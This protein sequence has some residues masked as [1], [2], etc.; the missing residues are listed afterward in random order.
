[1]RNPH[2]NVDSARNNNADVL[3]S[4]SGVGTALSS[5]LHA[6]TCVVLVWVNGIISYHDSAIPRSGLRL[7]SPCGSG[8]GWHVQ[9]ADAQP[10]P[11]THS[12]R[13]MWKWVDMMEADGDVKR[14]IKENLNSEP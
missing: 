5:F 4:T 13:K 10:T 9:T 14:L 12:L 3:E 7:K 6:V 2:R 1:M 8:Q 11:F